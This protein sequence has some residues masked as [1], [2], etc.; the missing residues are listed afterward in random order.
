M[1]M[2]SRTCLRSGTAAADASGQVRDGGG[3]RDVEIGG[4]GGMRDAESGR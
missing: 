1:K 3:K 4:R 2:E